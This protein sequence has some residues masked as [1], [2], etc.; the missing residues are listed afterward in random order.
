MFS[1]ID[2]NIFFT[3][4][5][6]CVCG[7]SESFF[8]FK[9]FIIHEL[10]AAASHVTYAFQNVQVLVKF[11]KTVLVKFLRTISNLLSDW[12]TEGV[13]TDKYIQ[14]TEFYTMAPLFFSCVRVTKIIGFLHLAVATPN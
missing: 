6:S 13:M 10:G 12:V 14:L 11:P 2:V 5:C 4:I 1:I 7:V 3:R 8:S 9:L